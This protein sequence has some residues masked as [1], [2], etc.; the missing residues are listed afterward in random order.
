MSVKMNRKKAHEENIGSN[1]AF[2]SLRYNTKHSHY[3][4]TPPRPLVDL[5]P[6]HVVTAAA[7]AAAAAVVMVVVCGVMC[8][9]L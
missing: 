9:L 5:Q 1:V 2:F 3:A 7:A 4:T 6:I 8:C